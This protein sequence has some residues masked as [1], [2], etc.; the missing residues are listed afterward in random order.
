M[1]TRP[2]LRDI[3][4]GVKDALG[5]CDRDTLLEVLTFVVKEYV[6]DGP[7]HRSWS[8]QGPEGRRLTRRLPRFWFKASDGDR[9]LTKVV[10]APNVVPAHA[11]DT[12]GQSPCRCQLTDPFSGK[13]ETSSNLGRIHQ[14]AW[15]NVQ[16]LHGRDR[17]MDLAYRKSNERTLFKTCDIPT[18]TFLRTLSNGRH[19][20]QQLLRSTESFCIRGRA[21]TD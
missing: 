7:P 19:G 4:T 10:P 11:P 15:G 6:V 8:V 21:P 5:D 18:F 12:W 13:I 16:R 1:P 9:P 14:L 3:T 20:W 2:D 17:T